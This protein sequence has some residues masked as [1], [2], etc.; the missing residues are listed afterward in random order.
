MGEHGPR[1][2]RRLV[3]GRVLVDGALVDRDVLIGTDG[4]IAGLPSPTATADPSGD[5]PERV[6]VSGL[7]VLPG[8]VNAHSHAYA[9]LSRRHI[10]RA[11]LEAWIPHAQAAAEALGPEGHAVAAGLNVLDNLRH[12]ATTTLDHSLFSPP[13]L[14]AVLDAYEA[15]GARTVLAFQVADRGPGD[16]LPPDLADL[17]S[18]FPDVPVAPAAELVARTVAAVERIAGCPRTTVAVG[19]SAPE[20]CTDELLAGLGA[21][22]RDHA[23]PVHVHLLETAMQA[24]H[25]D[26]VRRLQ[27][28]GLLGPAT[29]L[30]HAVHLGADDRARIA[31]AGAAVVHDPLCNLLLGSGRP[32]LPAMLDAGIRVGLGTDGW[33][34]G[35]AQDLVGQAR[36]ALGLPRPGL[37]EARWPAPADAWR[38]MTSGSAAAVGLPGELGAIEPGRR[39]DLLV[40]DPVR[41]G[42]LAGEDPVLQ[43]VWQGFGLGLRHVL[44]DGRDVLRDGRAVLV[45]EERLA[46]DGAR[47]ARRVADAGRSDLAD[48]L[49]VRWAAV[50]ARMDEA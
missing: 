2:A 44:V 7:V 21:V 26:G 14:D 17:A 20:R 27:D 10:A 39:A 25:P 8:L 24:R 9:Q 22:A 30:A 29:G 38:A 23:V 11:R 37:P 50:L 1:R 32:D 13:E 35:G 6:D 16:W 3:G 12:G 4:R 47:I 40:V 41:A 49:T 19:P 15:T 45:D 48:V 33:S 34:T 5:T 31:A 28:H 42:W 46:H 43:V 36:V 18:S